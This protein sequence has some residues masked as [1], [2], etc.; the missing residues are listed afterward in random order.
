M[1]GLKSLCGYYNETYKDCTF[2]STYVGILPP[3]VIL[4]TGKSL[5]VSNTKNTKPQVAKLFIILIGQNRQVLAG[6][7][8]LQFNP[9]RH[10]VLLIYL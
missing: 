7:S 1:W 6:V 4:K 3:L 5:P 2:G 8:H 9:R 10:M